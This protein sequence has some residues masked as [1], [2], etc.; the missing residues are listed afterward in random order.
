[1][2]IWGWSF[3]AAVSRVWDEIVTLAL[4][5]GSGVRESIRSYCR[6]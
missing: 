6:S 2:R 3:G 4:A 5:C 1:V